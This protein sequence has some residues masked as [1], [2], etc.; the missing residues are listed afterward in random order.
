MAKIEQFE[1]LQVWQK[2]REI[3]KA[4][5]LQTQKEKFAKDF[6]LK[7]QINRSA[8]SIMDNIAEGFERGGK[9]EFIQF[10]FI[11]KG[12]AGELRSQLHRAFDKE[13]ITKQ[14][15]EKLISEALQIGQ[16]LSGFIKYLKA[17]DMKGSKYTNEPEM[18]YGDISNFEL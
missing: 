11:A 18:Q 4:I 10:L 6:S 15:S 9:K 5:Y 13:Y 1:D 17:S 8:G 12:S 7:D 14:E 16:Q 3:A 2:A